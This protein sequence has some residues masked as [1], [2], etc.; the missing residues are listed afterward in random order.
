M[1]VKANCVPS[2]NGES[3]YSNVTSFTTL[4]PCP[5]PYNLA[6]DNLTYQSA[7]L[8]WIGFGDSYDLSYRTAGYLDVVGIEEPFATSNHTPTGWSRY[9][10]ELNSD[11]TASLSTTYYWGFVTRNLTSIHAYVNL[12]SYL[13]L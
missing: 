7:T 8:N 9:S 3:H 1:R 13:K 2:G 5:A 6:V 10:G 4:A 11:G 12:F